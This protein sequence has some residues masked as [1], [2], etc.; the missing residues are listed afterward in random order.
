MLHVT[1]APN[2]AWKPKWIE[3]CLYPHWFLRKKEACFCSCIFACCRLCWISLE[4]FV[5]VYFIYAFCL[6]LHTNFQSSCKEAVLHFIFS[7]IALNLLKMADCIRD[8]CWTETGWGSCFERTAGPWPCGNVY[9]LQNCTF[10]SC[11]LWSYCLGAHSMCSVAVGFLS[12]SH[13]QSCSYSI[14]KL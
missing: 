10:L 7:N 9:T 6:C 11:L 3:Q 2:G 12:S 13:M 8:L 5:T 4:T 1:V 14:Y